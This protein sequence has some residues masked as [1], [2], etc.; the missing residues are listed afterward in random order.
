M[1]AEFGQMVSCHLFDTLIRKN[2]FRQESGFR[3]REIE[4]L[5]RTR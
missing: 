3:P 5:E 2:L 1:T 4:L